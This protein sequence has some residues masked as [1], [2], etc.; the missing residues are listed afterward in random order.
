[1][2]IINY[3]VRFG[4]KWE[5]FSYNLLYSVA[6]FEQDKDTNLQKFID[7]SIFRAANRKIEK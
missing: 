7:I 5:I 2:N 3:M 4:T 6:F 1:M